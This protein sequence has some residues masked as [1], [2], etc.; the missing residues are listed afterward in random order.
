M[1]TVVTSLISACCPPNDFCNMAQVRNHFGLY[2][3]FN[4]LL[5]QELKDSSQREMLQQFSGKN[6]NSLLPLLLYPC[7][8]GGLFLNNIIIFFFYFM[9]IGQW[10]EDRKAYTGPVWCVP[11]PYM[12]SKEGN[13]LSNSN[14][15]PSNYTHKTCSYLNS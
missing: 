14:E 7:W 1:L 6:A 12:K 5:V 15:K 8:C 13:R 2:Q 4:D 11:H 3:H 9:L 10:K